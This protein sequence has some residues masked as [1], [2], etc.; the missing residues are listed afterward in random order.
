MLKINHAK[1]DYYFNKGIFDI[2]LE[3][4]KGSIVGLLGR[5][6]SGKSTLLKAIVNLIKLDEGEILLNDKPIY[7][8]YDKI[9]YISEAGS[10]ISY[11]SPKQYRDFLASYYTNFDRSLYD[12]MLEHFEVDPLGSIHSL[13]KGQQMKV[14][15]AAGLSMQADIYILDE[16]FNALDV[17]AKQDTIKYIL[18]LFDETKIVL[19]AT[20]NVEEIEQVIDRCIIME[21]GNIVEDVNMETLQNNNEDLHSLLLRYHPKKDEIQAS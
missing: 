3:I 20:H 14:E 8:Q 4:E 12:T 21:K 19:I 13:S 17:Y 10:Y 15:I 18:S 6:G 5:N 7:R 16:P 11:M 1:K 9:S 2:H